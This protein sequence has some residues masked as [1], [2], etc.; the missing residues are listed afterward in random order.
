MDFLSLYGQIY[1]ELKVDGKLV[2]RLPS[3]GSWE[4]YQ[5]TKYSISKD[6]Q[7]DVYDD[8]R[9]V[10]IELL[11]YDSDSVF[12]DTL[13]ID[14]SS[15]HGK[16][17]NVKYDIQK[18]TW[19]GDDVTGYS[20]G[21]RDGTQNTDDDDAAVWYNIKTIKWPYNR[22]YAWTYDNTEF[23]MD[24]NIPIA[25]YVNHSRSDI[26]RWPGSSGWSV[27][28]PDYV[29]YND[30]TLTGIAESLSSLASSKG[31]NQLQKASLVLRFVQYI[32]YSFDNAS[33]SQNEFWRYPLETLFDMTGDCE[34][35][36]ILYAAIMESMGF[37]AVLL[38]VPG[39]CAVGLD[40]PGAIGWKYQYDEKMYYYCETTNTGWKIGDMPLDYQTESA[41]IIPVGPRII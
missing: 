31:Y 38:L 36:F 41:E 34:A 33:K 24:V 12:S 23:F 21:S 10:N 3:T 4:F 39:H 13:D 22:H 28:G 5:G 7:F 20:D 2:S 19:T 35:S 25:S 30:A 16:T 26:E 8:S 9:Y 40:C 29:T 15:I 37:D 18:Q 27:Y 32:E 6:V 1:F 11:M 17:L 14:P